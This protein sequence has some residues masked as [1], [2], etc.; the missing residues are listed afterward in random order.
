MLFVS[1]PELQL[2]WTIGRKIPNRTSYP[3]QLS[4][5]TSNLSWYVANRELIRNGF[6]NPVSNSHDRAP[7]VRPGGVGAEA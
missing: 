7:L 1:T 3:L 5:S 2:D 4:S 6:Y